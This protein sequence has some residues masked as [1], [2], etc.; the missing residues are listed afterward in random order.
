LFNI[1]ILGIV[2]LM[3]DMLGLHATLTG[4]AL[5]PASIIAGLLWNAFGMAAPS[6]TAESSGWPPRSPFS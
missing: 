4:I 5:L 1:L 3:V 6:I 2:S